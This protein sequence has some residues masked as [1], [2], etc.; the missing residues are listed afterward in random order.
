MLQCV[1]RY[2]ELSGVPRDNNLKQVSTRHY[3]AKSTI[4]MTTLI[5]PASSRPLQPSGE[6]VP[7][8]PLVLC[9]G[10]YEGANS[11]DQSTRQATA[12]LDVLHE[13]DHIAESRQPHGRLCLPKC[14]LFLFTDSYFAGYPRTS[15]STMG[16]FM[17]FVGPNGFAPIAA[18]S[19]GQTAVSHNALHRRFADSGLFGCC[20][21]VVRPFSW[22]FGTSCRRRLHETGRRRIPLRCKSP[23]PDTI[24]KD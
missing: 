22:G 9:H 2:F 17:A 21:A 10:A 5:R 24:Y 15:K 7:M 14:K 20:H 13:F 6:N 23:K 4:V 8:R 11:M 16:L 12:W 1:D 18:T 19:K 3:W